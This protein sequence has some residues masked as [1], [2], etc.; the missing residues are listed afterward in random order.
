M[1]VIKINVSVGFR[2]SDIPHDTGPKVKL[3]GTELRARSKHWRFFLWLGGG[4]LYFRTVGFCPFKH[5]KNF[6]TL[7]STGFDIQ[8][9]R[10]RVQ[11]VHCLHRF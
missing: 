4:E 3:L 9:S 1:V 8:L 6:H 10:N 7:T 11:S 2:T 5:D